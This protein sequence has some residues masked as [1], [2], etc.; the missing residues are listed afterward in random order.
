MS[1]FNIEDL[2][3]IDVSQIINDKSVV[4]VSEQLSSINE[5]DKLY[6]CSKIYKNFTCQNYL[7]ICLPKTVTK[8]LST[9]RMRA[10]GLMIE[11]G[12]YFRPV[13][14]RNQ[15][16]CLNCEQVEDEIHLILFC[17]K[18]KDLRIL[19]FQRLNIHTHDLRP[20]MVEAFTVFSKLLN[21]T[22]YAKETKYICNYI[23]DAMKVR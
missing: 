11:R 1:D 22:N 14:P 10:L 20:N 9:L 12:R 18:F 4:E 16:G 7:S 15:R 3:D 19:L 8:E 17:S 2:D 6:T 21:P 5:A 23:S 13:M